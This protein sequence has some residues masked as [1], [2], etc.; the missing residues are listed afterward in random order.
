MFWKTHPVYDALGAGNH[1]NE[2][3][4]EHELRP[5]AQR[6]RIM[7]RVCLREALLAVTGQKL[8]QR[9]RLPANARRVLWYYD[10]TTLGDPIMDLSQRFA[11]PAGITLDL[12]MP[13]GPAELFEGDNRFAHVYRN[14]T[15]C[16]RGYDF[17]ILH[18]IGPAALR[19]KLLRHPAT[20][21]AAMI[22]HQQGER[23]ARIEFSAIRLGQLLGH[24]IAPLH[25]PRV[26]GR[27]RDGGTPHQ[28]GRVVV[29]LGSKDARRNYNHWPALLACIAQAWQPGWPPLRFVLT[30][31]GRNAHQDLAAF[32][33]E[34]LATHCEVLL[35]LPS[36]TEAVRVI[37]AGDLFLAPDG[38]LMHIA[39]ALDKP[40]L[41]LFS[42]LRPEWRLLPGSRLHTLY[43]DEVM[44]AI[45]QPAILES[46]LAVARSR[47]G[48][49]TV[50]TP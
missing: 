20:P 7:K 23:F 38:G 33:P 22:G 18:S 28:P 19:F 43:T 41:C 40:G 6:R 2:L 3:R 39:E 1:L 26:S 5:A 24:P 27:C 32:D 47:Y 46:F 49:G 9:N 48:A 25:R 36:L 8:L 31:G 14:E 42:K 50:G 11:F 13:R 4:R 35:D 29:V 16:P 15:D 10:W 12:C 44:D 34:F 30:G 37:D 17:I 45:P 21:F